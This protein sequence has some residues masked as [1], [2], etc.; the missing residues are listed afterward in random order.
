MARSLSA[1]GIDK[2][3]GIGSEMTDYSFGAYNS[4]NAKSGMV[5]PEYLVDGLFYQSNNWGFDWNYKG[6]YLTFTVNKKCNVWVYLY[7]YD[8]KVCFNENISI[9]P[10]NRYEKYNKGIKY[11]PTWFKVLKGLQPG[12]YVLK[13]DNGPTVPYGGSSN[14]CTSVQE[15]YFEEIEETFSVAIADKLDGGGG[16]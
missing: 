2:I 7:N 14:L 3:P 8:G 16:D 4:Y 12:T 11:S 1:I 15:I 5:K 6:D 9:T 10:D 13:R